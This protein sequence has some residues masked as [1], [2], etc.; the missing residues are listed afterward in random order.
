M[1]NQLKRIIILLA[2][3]A[4][5]GTILLVLCF[6]IPTEP[7]KQN[8]TNSLKSMIKVGDEVPQDSFSRYLWGKRET[9]TDAIMV[10]NAIERIADKNVFEHAM[11]V[12]HNDLEPEIWAPEE[13]LK[14]YCNPDD[15]STMYLHEYSRYWHGYLIYLKPLLL[16]LSW[17][18]ILWLGIVLQVLL[19]IAVFV[20]AMRRKQIEVGIAMLV[21]FAFMKPVLVLGSLTMA[22]CWL[23][24]L[25]A[26]LYMLLCHERLQ[27]KQW[28]AEVFLMIGIL[29]A[30]FDFLT[31]PVVTL[32]FPLCTY[33][34]LEKM[35]SIK[36][37]VRKMVA[38][39]FCWGV[40]YAGMWASKW[41]IADITLQTGTI[42]N[43]IWSIIGR[44]EAIGG[45][46]RMNGGWYVIDLNLQEYPSVF[47]IAAIVLAIAVA[48][49]LVMASVRTSVK[50]VLLQV[51]PFT[52]IFLI[53]FAWIV[54][55]QHHSALHA[56]F[57]FRIISVALMAVICMGLTLVRSCKKAT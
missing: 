26:M 9:Y 18:Q 20:A 25:A 13:S 35:P 42:K 53:P 5:I 57:T 4:V 23:I 40:G 47:V 33:F 54:V 27:E 48:V 17:K 11:W 41:V 55:V 3:S 30:Y 32:G 2:G 37:C 16:F 28:Y 52:I 45:R 29:T 1:V 31:Y 39:C 24:T 36:E 8:V 21:G 10:Q 46:P 15:D 12:Y 38:F 6:C 34:L 50:Q 19:M 44:T 14:A 56:R 22:V 43:A 49:I 51:M 7:M